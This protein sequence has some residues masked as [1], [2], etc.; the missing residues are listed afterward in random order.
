V[1]L[2]GSLSELDWGRTVRLAHP[3]PGSIP[4][5]LGL[6]TPISDFEPR[7]SD[8]KLHIFG[9]ESRISDFETRVFGLKLGIF[10]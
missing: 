4:C 5:I 9:F 6:E 2:L 8:F 7:I 1:A 10:G 3:I